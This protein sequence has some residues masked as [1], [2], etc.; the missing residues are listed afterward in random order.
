MGNITKINVSGD[1]YDLSIS[2][3]GTLNSSYSSDDVADS[4]ASS[5]A[6]VNKINNTDTNANI[7]NK[8]TKS[9]RN[10][11]YLNNTLGNSN[12][13]VYTSNNK[14]LTIYPNLRNSSDQIPEHDHTVDELPVST[15]NINS[16]EYIPTS[17]LLYN[18]DRNMNNIGPQFK[19]GEDFTTEVT[20][21]N[22]PM[23]TKIYADDS[24]NY[25]IARIL[26]LDADR[27]FLE[28]I[29]VWNSLS[30]VDEFFSIYNHN[31]NYSGLEIGNIIT[32]NDGTFDQKWMIAGFDCEH[33]ITAADGTVYDNGYGICLVPYLSIPESDVLQIPWNQENNVT[34]GYISSY[35]HSWLNTTLYNALKIVCGNHIVNRDVLLSST[36]DSTT[37]IPS[38]YTWT[39]AY[40]TSLSNTQFNH[41]VIGEGDQNGEGTYMLPL[42]RT[43]DPESLFPYQLNPD[44]NH[45]I[46][47][48]MR[49]RAV[50]PSNDNK[51]TNVIW[52]FNGYLYEDAYYGLGVEASA[53]TTMVNTNVNY[54]YEVHCIAFPMMYLR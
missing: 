54:P 15:I 9:L 51:P 31:N 17:A 4:S 7:F 43:N 37:Q 3:N 20:L 40:L 38:A 45:V 25:I 32:I 49:T 1:T 23:G 13:S 27:N 16:S 34:G 5:Y 28:H 26:G 35:I 42:F 47:Y 14:Q 18:L 22:L 46:S 19:I 30:D 41:H 53:L 2:A 8:I 29:A 44:N 33:N 52:G 11:R 48:G 50:R 24:I 6:E 10:T 39:T 12:T 21:G 36:V